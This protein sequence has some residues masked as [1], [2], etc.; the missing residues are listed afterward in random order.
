MGI[1]EWAA[2]WIGGGSKF[3]EVC[4]QELMSAGQEYQI[5]ELA[6]RTCVEM[7]ANAIGRC[8]F[9]T[10]ENW[11]EVRGLD[12]YL[13]NYQPNVNQNSTQFWHRVVGLLYLKN[14][15]LIIPVKRYGEKEYSFV[16]ADDWYI[17]EPQV[18]RPNEY[19]GVVVGQFQFNKTFSEDDV[20][21]LQLHHEHVKPVV[22]GLFSSYGRLISAAMNNY[23]WT[24]G[25][26]WKVSVN[27]VAG[28][29]D[30]WA[31]EF[32]QIIE[33]Q[34]KPFLNAQSAVL[35]EMEGYK[36]ELVG[37]TTPNDAVKEA[38]SIR[39]LVQDI[40]DFTANAFL[41]PPVLLRGQVEGIADANNRF[42]TNCVDPL[43]DQIGEEI[44][45]K[46][47]GFDG[48][49][50]GFYVKADTSAIGHFNLFENA[51]NVEKLIGTGYSYND[52]QRAAGGLEIQEPWADE[53]FL[54]RNFAKAEELLEGDENGNGTNSEIGQSGTATGGGE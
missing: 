54:T 29:R 22:D 38:A 7:V 19:K 41:I 34:I 43:A 33:A 4:V 17:P 32:R 27:Q 50:R 24:N 13:W 12:H 47:C 36:Y 31:E 8:D 44:T 26:H 11:K 23:V 51:P 45:R 18:T 10:Y 46:R 30:K 35:P 39:N 15:V 16:A 48:W 53:H 6:F 9:R 5:R 40:F 49:Q 25:Q 37:K 42:L 3:Q 20:I 14:E 52:I 1:K 2:K 21:H 28:G